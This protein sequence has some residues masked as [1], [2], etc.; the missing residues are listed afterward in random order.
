MPLLPE[1]T[2]LVPP[3]LILYRISVYFS[4]E[5]R[6][7]TKMMS[8]QTTTDFELAA[9]SSKLPPIPSASTIKARLK[10][11]FN[12]SSQGLPPTNRSPPSSAQLEQKISDYSKAHLNHSNNKANSAAQVKVCWFVLCFHQSKS[13]FSWAQFQNRQ[14]YQK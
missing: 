7:L 4:A 9:A 8:S 11:A 14:F 6:R 2:V 3:I 10:G 1:F 5:K 13:A 12:R